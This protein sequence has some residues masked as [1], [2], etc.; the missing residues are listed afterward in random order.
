MQLAGR[1]AGKPGYELLDIVEGKGL[2][3]LPEPSAGDLFFDMEGD[4]F[5]GNAGMEY[6]FGWMTQRGTH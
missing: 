6:L 3:N 4:P 5:I 2:S 1:S